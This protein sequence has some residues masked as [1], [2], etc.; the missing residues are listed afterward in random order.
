[1]REPLN[2]A[3][4]G[5][6]DRLEP[7][8]NRLQEGVLAVDTETT[9][10]RW[11]HD[12]VGGLCLA[13]GDTAIYCYGDAL[14]N[15]VRWLG[16]QAKAK[17]PLVFHNAKFDLHML[18][19]TFGLKVSYP[20]DDTMIMSFLIDDRGAPTESPSVHA[21]HGLKN[22]A[23]AYV[24]PSA[25]EP[26]E[27]L[28]QAVIAAGGRRSKD[29]WK[30]DILMAPPTIVGEYGLMDAWYT[31][32]LY[33][34][35][36]ERIDHWQQPSEE[37]PPLRELYRTEQ[38]LLL[39]LVDMEER[40][41]LVDGEF[42]ERWKAKLTRKREKIV[43]RLEKLAGTSIDWTSTKQLR[44]LL[45]D[46]MGLE[47]SHLTKKGVPS[48]DEVSLLNLDHPIGAELLK[49]RDVDKQL[50]TYAEGLLNSIWD[51]GRIHCTFRQTGART[52]RLSCANPNLQ[53]V[54]RESGA[55]RGFIPDDGLELRFADYSQVEMRFAAHL[56]N[57]PVLVEGFLHNPTFDTHAATAKK[58]YGLS[59]E[60]TKQQRKFAKIMNF[61]ML[62]GAGEDKITSQLIS[63][64]STK[65]ARRSCIELGYRPSPAES[66]H[67]SLAQLLRSIYFREFPAIKGARY[68]AQ[69][70]VKARGY[71]I[72]V[73]GRHRYLNENEIYKAFNTEIQGSAADQ[74]KRGLADMYREL[75]QGEGSIAILLQIH[76]EVV[77]LS[78]GDPKT[79]R[80]VLEILNEENRFRVPIVADVS[81]SKTSWQ[82]KKGIEL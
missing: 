31:L 50:S 54:P 52:G 70:V 16:D 46:R 7:W 19:G 56:S 17:R 74:A 45:F 71:A 66:P 78:D 79:D 59:G 65:E 22:L 2:A 32:Q 4:L 36:N 68:R 72:N 77:Y 44:E 21:G 24:D 41:I 5:S 28:R 18:R 80:K 48:T 51:D 33:H 43:R 11:D 20:V 40:G 47:P 27:R 29:G 60:P 76:D 1:M 63:L 38:W 73:F 62:Y 39:A 23:A 42:F 25:K 37:Y 75:Q 55:R 34:Q 15:A 67:R 9:G 35:F 12:R 57:D 6:P 82:D 58:M 10:L 30:A 81:G 64:L 61:A 13:A 3:I 53:Q 69:D 49:L 14:G 26:E 8:L